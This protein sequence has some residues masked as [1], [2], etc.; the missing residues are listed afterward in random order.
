[1][2]PADPSI[3]PNQLAAMTVL[4]AGVMNTPDAYTLR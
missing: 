2:A 3:D 4:T 1:V